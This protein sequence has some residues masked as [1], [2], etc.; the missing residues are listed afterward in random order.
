MTPCNKPTLGMQEQAAAMRV[1]N[2]VWV[3]QGA[4]VE[5]F[6]SELCRFF[7]VPEGYSLAVSSRP[8]A[9]SNAVRLV[10]GKEINLDCAEGNSSANIV[11]GDVPAIDVLIAPS[12]FGIPVVLP[13]KCDYKVIEGIA[14]AVR[15]E[16][17]G[18]RVGLRSALGIC[19]FYAR[20]LITIGRQGGTVISRNKVLID[21]R[22][23]CREFYSRGDKKI[24]SNFLMADVLAAIGRSPLDCLLEFIQCRAQLFVI[25]CKARLELL[26][27]DTQKIKPVCFRA[28]IGCSQ[29][30]RIIN[31][32]AVVW[33]RDIV[34]VET[35]GLQ[36][37]LD[38]YP[39]VQVL[40]R[41]IVSLPLY[42]AMN[43]E[44]MLRIA[45]ISKGAA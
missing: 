12:I 4:K 43:D 37:T 24:R 27:V 3:A 35:Y 20:K 21:K 30:A 19:S 33:V 36:A 39:L 42:P 5:A 22:T 45:R 13:A 28:A 29:P 31:T 25:Y 38:R 40:T 14:Q 32:M 18:E 34:P 17:D 1:L 26:G 23:D 8:T 10:G 16:S 7:G 9:L 15:T 41:T 2:S 11:R 44:D 6:E